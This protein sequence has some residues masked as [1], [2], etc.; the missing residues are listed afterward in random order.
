MFRTSSKVDGT[1][2]P[3]PDGLELARWYNGAFTDIFGTFIDTARRYGPVARVPFPPGREWF[4]V[5]SPDGVAHVLQDNHRNYI[6]GLPYRFLEPV[7]G[8]GLVTSDGELW[9]RQ[10]R[11]VAPMFHRSRMPVWAGT[12]VESTA[13]L[14]DRWERQ[15]EDE[16]IDVADQL[17]ELTLS[18]A[19]KLLF[20][21]D[22]GAESEWIGDH[23]TLILRDTNR[24][25]SNPMAIPRG[26]PTPHN[27]RV[28]RALQEF[29]DFVYELIE[30][31]RGDEEKYDD[32]LSTFMLAE[33]E[34]GEQMSDKQIRDEVITFIIAGHETTASHLS[35]T[36]YLLAEHPEVRERVEREVDEQL[37]GMMPTME[38]VRGLDYLEQ[39]IDESMRLYPPAWTI[40][41]EPL[42][43]D[44]IEGFHIPAG[45][46]VTVGPYFVH[47]NAQVWDDVDEFR[48]ERFGPDADAPDHRYA[49]FPFGG[50]P[51]MCAGADF[52]ILEAKLILSAVI[53]R[54]RL[55]L[56]EEA[57]VEP[58]ATATIRP[59]DGLAMT[60]RR[61]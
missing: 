45:S 33:D 17:M 57:S 50:G 3:G 14:L 8:K 39:V 46:T 7:V 29:D 30:D 15:P 48:P 49:H 25:I 24:R 23:L 40:E 13:G 1:S 58:E 12:M 54:F 32:V 44:V 31:R 36:F 27:R 43:D 21:R 11:L 9:R 59:R 10:R 2:A 55:D 5:S 22:F 53:R 47:R 4:I 6:K 38:E 28:A 35:W 52:A 16:P 37:S 41:R 18:I 60:L 42:E 61:R 19:G 56:V 20:N 26:V 34:G 51:R